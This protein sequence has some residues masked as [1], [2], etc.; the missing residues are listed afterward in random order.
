VQL[1]PTKV[2]WKFGEHMRSDVRHFVKTVLCPLGSEPLC[3]R[4]SHK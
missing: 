3:K 4:D 1:R 2:V